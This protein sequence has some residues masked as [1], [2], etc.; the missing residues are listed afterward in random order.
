MKWKRTRIA[1]GALLIV[2]AASALANIGAH[3]IIPGVSSPAFGYGPAKPGGYSFRIDCST[4]WG[5]LALAVIYLCMSV[6]GWKLI[7]NARKAKSQPPTA[8]DGLPR[9]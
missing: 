9:A 3:F 4:W 6:G 2:M 8:G 1:F 7:Q 5:T